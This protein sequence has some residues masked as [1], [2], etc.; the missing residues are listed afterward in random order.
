MRSDIQAA[1]T[2]KRVRCSFMFEEANGKDALTGQPRAAF[3]L[4][5]T[6]FF[7]RPANTMPRQR[8]AA[9][10]RQHIQTYR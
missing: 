8:H 6:P 1:L 7:I 5:T 4:T 10:S 2:M 9:S 3:P